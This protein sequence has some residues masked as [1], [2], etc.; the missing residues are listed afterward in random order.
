MK[1]SHVVTNKTAVNIGKFYPL[2]KKLQKEHL[3][4][5]N[6][7]LN[8][9]SLTPTFANRPVFPSINYDYSLISQQQQQFHHQYQMSQQHQMR[10]PQFNIPFMPITQ[11][12]NQHLN[13]LHNQYLQSQ[14]VFT[15]NNNNS[16]Y[17]ISDKLITL[18]NLSPSITNHA[19]AFKRIK[20]NRTTNPKTINIQE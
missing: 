20:D 12:F 6:N 15:H 2:Q 7:N 16:Q 18:A 9:A 13:Q 14:S 5:I 1:K 10:S 4:N 11:G 19:P 3:A 8:Y 17:N